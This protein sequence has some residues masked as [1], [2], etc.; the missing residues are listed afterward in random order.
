MEIQSSLLF[1]RKEIYFWVS[2]NFLCNFLLCLLL[3]QTIARSTMQDPVFWS[4]PTNSS[5]S[6]SGRR[7]CRRCLFKPPNIHTCAI[8]WIYIAPTSSQIP[9]KLLKSQFASIF[10]FCKLERHLGCD[11]AFHSGREHQDLLPPDGWQTE[12]QWQGQGPPSRYVEQQHLFCNSFF[13][14]FIKFYSLG[15]LNFMHSPLPSMLNWT[16]PAILVPK[17]GEHCTLFESCDK[18]IILGLFTG[19]QTP[20]TLQ[21]DQSR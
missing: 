12:S 11:C 9:S 1:L 4:E 3:L 13:W 8:F 15:D 21:I 5:A 10:K 14:V 16:I 6:T 2:K 19:T 7:Q 17:H 18:I 20:R